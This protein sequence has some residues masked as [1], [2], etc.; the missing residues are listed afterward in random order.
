MEPII[1]S[2]KAY[3]KSAEGRKKVAT[4]FVVNEFA[5]KDGADIV[6]I[7]D[8][9]PIVCQLVRNWFGY[10]FSPTSAY[11]TVTHNK[12]VGGAAKS[13]HIYGMAVDIPTCGKIKPIELYNFLDNL[14]S[15][16]CEIGLYSWGVHFAPTKEKRRFT[17]KSYKEVK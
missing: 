11:R 7:N 3:S 16:S 9:L 8:L 1:D 5:S 2:F 10:S 14:F 15:D 4:N 6:I 13:N 12:S 17:D